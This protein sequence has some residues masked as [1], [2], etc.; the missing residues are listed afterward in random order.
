MAAGSKAVSRRGAR[1]FVEDETEKEVVT[2]QP[3][4][5]SIYDDTVLD[6][7]IR[8]NSTSTATSQS[9]QSSSLPTRQNS[10]DLEQVTDMMSMETLA[11]ERQGEFSGFSG[12]D[13]V[14]GSAQE[15]SVFTNPGPLEMLPTA[16]RP[17]NFGVVVPGVYRSSFPQSGDYSFIESLKLKTI[18]TLVQKDFPEG[19]EGFIRKNSIKHHVFNMK[20]T[21]KEEIP[22]KTMKS[23]L[24]LVLDQKNHPLLVH[25]NHGKHRTGCVVGVVRKISGWELGHILEE[26][27]NYAEPKIRDCDVKYIKG[28]KLTEIANLFRPTCWQFRTNHFLRNALFT[29]AIMVIWMVTIYNYRDPTKLLK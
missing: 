5:V 8:K 7:A 6:V 26:Y 18:V 2:Y 4:R 22:I 28:F 10:L 23:I 12:A 29:V 21:K 16:G 3:R 9:S 1:L 19:Y 17:E 27:R 25:C 13:A 15:H 11:L 20:G 24:R 14:F